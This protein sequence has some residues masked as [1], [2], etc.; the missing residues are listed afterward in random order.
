VLGAKVTLNQPNAN[1]VDATDTDSQGAFRFER[2]MAGTYDV[3]VEQPGFKP[4]VSRI[5]AGTQ[6]L[7]PLRVVLELAEVR[8]EVTVAAETTQVS[9]ETS[10]NLDTVTMDRSALDNLP[11]FDQDFIG[12]M[13]RFLEAGSIGT[14]GVTLVVDGVEA[15]RAGVS[16]SAIQEVRLN[17]DPY[18]SEYTRPGRGRIEIITK[19]GSSAYHGTFNF[20]FRDY[21]LNA[22]DPFALLR[23]RSSAGFWK[24]ISPDLLTAVKRRPSYF[25]RIAK[26]KTH[27]RRFSRKD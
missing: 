24:E 7:R 3:V 4:F 13:S 15:T 21:R 20:L 1:T 16:A 26:K 5:R 10:E 17:Q 11:I 14:N 25:R 27:K 19:P 9:T 18:S 12:T 22:R 2:V 23:P 6:E 8:Q